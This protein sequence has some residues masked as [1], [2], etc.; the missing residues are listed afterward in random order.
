MRTIF[1]VSVDV[2]SQRVSVAVTGAG[3]MHNM[4]RIIVG[5]LVDVGRGRL[6]EGAVA[7]A[8]ASGDRTSGGMTAPPDGLLLDGI[9]LDPS[10][11]LDESWPF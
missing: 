5:T 4:V 2:A 8:L 6:A 3:F 10:V 11:T 7:R 1:C 9:A